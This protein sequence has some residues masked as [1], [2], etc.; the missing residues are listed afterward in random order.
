[1]FSDKKIDENYIEKIVKNYAAM[2]LQYKV[3]TDEF[4]TKVFPLPEIWRFFIEGT[5]QAE[6]KPTITYYAAIDAKVKAYN[7][8]F[9]KTKMSILLDPTTYETVSKEVKM[10]MD[11]HNMDHLALFQKH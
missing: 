10:V 4:I 3:T 6:G 2:C 11:E 5:R 9:L 1:M 7:F 8:S